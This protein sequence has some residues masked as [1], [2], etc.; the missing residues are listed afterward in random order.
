[1]QS[2]KKNIANGMLHGDD[3]TSVRQKHNVPQKP[4]S[5]QPL[6]PQ[7]LSVPLKSCII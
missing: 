2:G 3:I 5:H 6:C 1:M 7:R 4:D